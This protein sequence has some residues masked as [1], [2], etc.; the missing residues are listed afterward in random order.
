MIYNYSLTIPVSTSISDPL[1]QSITL[2]PG[3][4]RKLDIEFP[5]GCQGRV[6]VQIWRSIHQLWPTNDQAWFVSD[7]YTISFPEE[8]E[9]EE[10]P[11]ELTLKGY[12]TSTSQPHTIKFRFGVLPKKG[13]WTESLLEALFGKPKT[14]EIE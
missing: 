2:V 5:A 7:D 12:N 1:E 10:I 11:W 9:L 8:Y 14:V 6:G 4:I 13:V 3:I